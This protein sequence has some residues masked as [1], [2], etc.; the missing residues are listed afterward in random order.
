MYAWVEECGVRAPLQCVEV[1]HSSVHALWS[2]LEWMRRLALR[3]ALC[4]QPWL[5]CFRSPGNDKERQPCLR[6]VCG[7]RL[8]LRCPWC[9]HPARPLCLWAAAR[10]MSI[11]NAS[12]SSP[13]CAACS[14]DASTDTA[15]TCSTLLVL[16]SLP[17]IT[18]SSSLKPS[19]TA[20]TW[21]PPFPGAQGAVI[22]P[23]QP[24]SYIPEEHC[25]ADIKD[26]FSSFG[27]LMPIRPL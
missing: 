3:T 15:I 22:C 14:S 13:S 10:P 19:T 4:P 5:Q 25:W 23:V 16:I 1:P 2:V 24:G 17:A 6:T 7:C 9:T 8:E 26:M 11:S 12:M 27:C 18:S 21:L 20:A